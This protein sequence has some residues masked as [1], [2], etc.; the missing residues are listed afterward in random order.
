MLLIVYKSFVIISCSMSSLK[1]TISS[2]NI[3]LLVFHIQENV[4][5]G[6]LKCGK[7]CKSSD[8]IS[9]AKWES[10]QSKTRNWS[11]LDKFG[12][13]YESTSWKDGPRDHYMHQS[14]YIS[15]SSSDK[16]EKARQRKSKEHEIDQCP[17]TTSSSETQ[18]Q[19]VTTETT[20]SSETQPQSACVHLYV[21]LS[22]TKQSAYGACV[23]K[24]QSTQ[25]E[26]EES[27][28]DSTHSQHGVHLN[29]TQSS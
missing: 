11:G 9:Q 6:I 14:C 22:T 3:I 23:V 19:N 7:P 18:P 8:I 24:T 28:F 27:C 16:L 29:A 12:S 5:C 2:V 17:L 15:I 21:G 1:K 10:L 25:I 4:E 20:S 26:R 13:V